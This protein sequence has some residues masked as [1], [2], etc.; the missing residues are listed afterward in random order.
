MN[1]ERKSNLRWI[2]I[3]GYL[4]IVVFLLG[5]MTVMGGSPNGQQGLLRLEGD[6]VRA[7]DQNGDWAPVAGTSTFE[8]IGN[9]EGTGPW[10]V[11]GRTFETNESTQT[12]D[13]LQVGD[14]VHVRG[15]ALEDEAWV[16]YSIERAQEQ[17]DPVVTLIGT[18]TS[19]DPWVVN[20]I[21]LQVTDETLVEGEI[22]PGMLVRVEILLLEDGTW[23]VISI[24][25]LGDPSDT[26]GCA[27]VIATVVRVDG[28]QIQ[29]LGWPTTV[30]LADEN[31]NEDDP[32]DGDPVTVQP[33]QEV[34][35]VVCVVNNQVVIVNITILDDDDDD[36]AGA[37]GG[38][39]VLV[40]HKPSKNPH[41]LSISSSA[42]P[43]HLGH[44]DTLGPCP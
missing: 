37:D 38:G 41:T 7:Q 35:A 43:A 8:L 40:C 32:E 2:F 33:G 31:E 19:V 1:I 27:N 9:L 44:G 21:T 30:T 28:N 12:E 20:G 34:L 15:A 36:E 18:V 39:K 5:C 13:G 17:T 10:I 26:A 24:A 23:E 14:L 6:V 3:I 42:V 11:A 4:G 22:T 29:F 25:P 16:A